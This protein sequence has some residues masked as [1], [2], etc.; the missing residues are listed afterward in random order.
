[1][2]LWNPGIRSKVMLPIVVMALVGGGY[3]YGYWLPRVLARESAARLNLMHRQ[4][5]SVTAALIPMILSQQMDTLNEDLSALKKRNP[6]WTAIRLADRY[7]RQRRGAVALRSGLVRGQ[8]NEDR[9]GPDGIDDCQQPGEKL[10]VFGP[11][12]HGLS[13][14]IIT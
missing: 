9:D 6:E 13:F 10:G 11:L 7:G 12:V 5:A 4:M 8:G 1:M 14:K 2:R 3:F